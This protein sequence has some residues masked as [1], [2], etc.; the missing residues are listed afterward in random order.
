M[1]VSIAQVLDQFPGRGDQI[2]LLASHLALPSAS[3]TPILVHGP[4]TT[5]KTSIL[6]DLL[7]ALALKHAYVNCNYVSRVRATATSIYHQL[8]GTKR[9]RD[10]GYDFYGSRCDS[11]SDFLLK[12]PTVAPAN[13]PPCWIVLDNAQ[14]LAGTELLTALMRVKETTGA[15]VGLILISPLPWASGAFSRDAFSAVQPIS[16]EFSAYT[17]KQLI[18]V[19]LDIASVFVCV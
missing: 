11:T 3:S 10:E 5:G 1:P 9:Q 2:K 16:V 12:L 14:R 8:R 7:Q 13:K 17:A 6:R 18:K 19:S 15:N 4:Q